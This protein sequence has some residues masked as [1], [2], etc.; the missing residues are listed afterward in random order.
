MELTTK[1]TG[2]GA[3]SLI[4]HEILRLKRELGSDDVKGHSCEHCNKF[5]IKPLV[6]PYWDWKQNIQYKFSE[7]DTT[8]RKVRQ[9]GETGCDFW[10]MIRDQ[11]IYIGLEATIKKRKT[12]ISLG[13]KIHHD[14]CLDEYWQY[15]AVSLGRKD[16]EEFCRLYRQRGVSWSVSAGAI[17]EVPVTETDFVRIKLGY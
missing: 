8:G 2:H 10:I 15:I 17:I 5:R 11:L 7:I 14:H 9:L 4:D 3:A 13:S 12:K 1:G 6:D 16:E